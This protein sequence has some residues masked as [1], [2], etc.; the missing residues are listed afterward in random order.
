MI[1]AWSSLS[2]TWCHA[3]ASRSVCILCKSRHAKVRKIICIFI[4]CMRWRINF[5]FHQ[6]TRYKTRFII[7]GL[8]TMQVYTQS[9]PAISPS[10]FAPSNVISPLLFPNPENPTCEVLIYIKEVSS[11]G[12]DQRDPSASPVASSVTSAVDFQ[13]DNLNSTDLEVISP[14]LSSSFSFCCLIPFQ[15]T[16][17]FPKLQSLTSTELWLITMS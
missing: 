13:C 5:Y 9:V 15:D 3:K 6:A 14:F 11:T 4:S 1:C 2:A 8:Y 16:V 7:W 12:P 17:M 10:Y